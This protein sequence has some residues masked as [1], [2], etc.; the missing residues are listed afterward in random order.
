MAPNGLFPK[1][2]TLAVSGLGI[3]SPFVAYSPTAVSEDMEVL[4]KVMSALGHVPE[5]QSSIMVNIRYL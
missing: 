3:W 4:Q 5:V 1:S 2:D